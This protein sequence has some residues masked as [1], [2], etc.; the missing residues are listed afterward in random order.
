MRKFFQG[1]N[2]GFDRMGNGYGAFTRRAVRLPMIVLPVYGVLV[3]LAYYQFDRAPTGFIPEQDQG[4]VI[5]VVQLPPGAALNRTD[6]VVQQA[7]EILR[8]LDGFEHSVAF[9][10]FDGATF[11]N[12]S[13]SG[14]IFTTLAP[15]AERDAAGLDAPTLIARANEALAPIQEAFIITIAPPSVRGIGNSGG[16]KMMVQDLRGRGLE[17]LESATQDLV[18]TANQSE[19]V[20]GVFTLFNTRTPR[21]YADLDRVRAQMLGV[22]AERLFETLEVY[23]GSSYVNDFNFLGRPFRVTAQADGAFRQDIEDIADLWTRNEHGEMVP[24]GAVTEFRSTTGPQRVPR[25]NLYQAAEVQGSAAA[26]TS[27]GEALLI[28]EGLAEERL[29]DG[30][31]FAWTELAFQERQADTGLAVFALS[32]IFAFL[33]LAALYESWSL[34]LAVILIVPMGLLAAVT[35]LLARGMPVDVL[36]QVSFIVLVALAAK[37]AIL[38]VEFAK[39]A[40]ESGESHI[41]AAITAA[42]TRLRPIL[43]TS[44]AFIF[45]VI[46][47]MIA[48]GAG[49]EMRQT[50]GTGV[51]AGMVGVTLFGLLFTPAFYTAVRGAVLRIRPKRPTTPTQ[52]DPSPATAA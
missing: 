1:F 28:M 9:A 52:T 46:P 25:F 33:L 20:A 32:V 30:F 23:L 29:P 17:A 3:A 22:S 14:A 27:T 21:I 51:F 2:W 26:G 50:L 5:T 35:G 37:N 16:Y 15:F 31:S 19:G 44:F 11:T 42:T 7:A 39:Q 18:A 38:I 4:Y 40:E 6:A 34:P 48:T 43:M 10:G 47:L 36:G 24:I 8:G 49:A 13:N 45:G 41:Q 12:A